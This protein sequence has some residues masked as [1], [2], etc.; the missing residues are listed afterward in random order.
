MN[1]YFPI[2]K[3]IDLLRDL[4]AIPS[5]NPNNALG[6]QL[7][8]G[9]NNISRFISGRLAASGARVIE[10]KVLKDR[11][12]IIAF[13]EGIN[14]NAT[15]IIEGHM[16][17]VDVVNMNIPPFEGIYKDG[18]VYG[19]GACDDKGSLA[20]MILCCEALHQAMLKPKVNICMVATVDEEYKYRGVLKFIEK[21]SRE[22]PGVIGAVVMEPTELQIVRSHK[23]CVRW[24]IKT[25]GISAHS[26]V[27]SHGVNAIYKMC[28]VVNAIISNCGDIYGK[29]KHPLLGSPT[30]NVGVIKGGEDVTIV[31]NSC[32]IDIDRRTNPGEIPNDVVEEV[33]NIIKGLQ[34]DDPELQFMVYQPYEIDYPLDTPGNEK[35]IINLKRAT[36]KVINGATIIGA[37]YG[38]NASKFQQGGIPAVVF[39]PG[40]IDQAH[41]SNEYVKISH[42][43]KAAKILYELATGLEWT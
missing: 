40:S 29:N 3:A 43:T 38:T 32:E 42:V 2:E 4:I 23:G 8:T 1:R 27:P 24:K 10:Q 25:S 14:K 37:P 19:R 39:G 17:T 33:S 12:N 20:A 26:S 22:I 13:V 21:F 28:K 41:S 35:I 36:K 7:N 11:D 30:I 18:K 9:E 15:L 16:D 5:V 6:C 34:T 31:P